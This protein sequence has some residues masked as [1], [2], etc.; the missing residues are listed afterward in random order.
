MRSHDAMKSEEAS[1]AAWEAA[2]GGVIGAFKWGVGAA[3]LGAAGYIWSPLYRSMTVQFKVYLQMC[4]MV[5][6]GMI[7]ADS[8]LRAYEQRIRME[9]RIMGDRARRQRFEEEYIKGDGK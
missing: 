2:R 3:V 9:R 6:G 7:E 4:G 8:R 5:P 1:D